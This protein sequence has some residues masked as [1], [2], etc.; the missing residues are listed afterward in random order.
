MVCLILLLLAT[1]YVLPSLAMHP[2]SSALHRVRDSTAFVNFGAAEI[3][4]AQREQLA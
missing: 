3:Q 1:T 4:Q 2:A